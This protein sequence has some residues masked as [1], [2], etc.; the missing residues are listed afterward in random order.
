[1]QYWQRRLQRS[2][3]D[4]RRLRS[5]RSKRSSVGIR[6]HYRSQNH[7][8]L[9]IGDWRLELAIGDCRLLTGDWRMATII[10]P[11]SCGHDARRWRMWMS[12]TVRSLVVTVGLA[13]CVVA[14]PLAQ[15]GAPKQKAG[16]ASQFNTKLDALKEEAVADV[17]GRRQMA[18]RMV[19]QIFSYGELGFQE[20]ETNRYLIDIL[21]TN[22]FS[23]QQR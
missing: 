21:T 14:L 2:V 3:T 9:S 6:H 5:G 18:Q 1:M 20:F 16:G 7:C 11:P 15:K 13:A 19:D 22:G 8:R 17:D 4:T 10:G 23:V 12:S